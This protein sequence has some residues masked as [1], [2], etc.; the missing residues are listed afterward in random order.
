[1]SAFNSLNGVPASANPF[2]LKQVLRKEWGFKGLVMSDWFGGRDAIGQMKA[3]N[4]LLMPGTPNQSKAIVDAVN[5]GTLDVKQL[6]LNVERILKIVLLS[7]E[8]KKYKYSEK[9]DLAKDAQVAR[10][11]A[12]E[13]MVLLKN[14]N[15]SLPF[16]NVKKVAVFGN[17]SYDIIPGGTGSG[18][19][20]KAYTVSLTQGLAN[21]GYQLDENLKNNY[22]QYIADAKSKQPKQRSF[23]AL[24]P[25]IPELAIA[26]DLPVQ[27][28][29]NADAAII[30]IGRNAGEGADRK[31]EN[32]YY[33]SAEEK[34]LIKN[35][36]DAFHAKNKKLIV[37]LNI[38]GVMEIASWKDMA[39]AILLAWQP[40]LEAGNA[41]ADIL[42]GKVN[43]SG[44]LATTFP[45]D[46]NDVPSAK[47]FPGKELKDTSQTARP[48]FGGKPSEVV[49]EE[50]IYVGYRYYNTFNVKPAYPFG[51]GLSYTGF[52]Y[53]RLTLSAPSLNGK[54]TATITVTNSGLVAGKEVVQLYIS[55]P[56]K[57]LDKPTE[58]L[59]AGTKVAIKF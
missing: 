52:S 56:A 39:D 34:A 41:I 45:V 8:F 36:G 29:A 13:G 24:P 30:T 28:A 50:G 35:I 59:K 23:F 44:K 7:P 19:V 22:Q 17:I 11:A 10:L 55:A 1:M 12:T 54:I 53:G 51:F 4:D 42:S 58:E 27:E 20:N 37:V 25:P 32:D 21:A 6:D 47:N 9:P 26:A 49:Y 18:N 38:G 2:T 15:N 48:G 31:L 57:M 16:K 5:K 33:L 3:G 40:G 14:D 46:Y 43:P